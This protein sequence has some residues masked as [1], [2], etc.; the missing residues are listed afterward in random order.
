MMMHCYTMMRFHKIISGED[1]Y[2]VSKSVLTYCEKFEIAGKFIQTEK[3]QN[4]F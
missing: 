1:W 3:G 4:N 2:F